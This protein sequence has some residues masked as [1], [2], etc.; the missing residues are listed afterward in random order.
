MGGART[1]P[2][3]ERLGE[4]YSTLRRAVPSFPFDASGLSSR[5]KSKIIATM[6]KLIQGIVEYRRRIRPAYREKFARLAL[7]QKPDALLIACSDS[8]VVPNLFASTEPGDLFVIRNVGN[9][10]PPFRDRN[11]RGLS[12]GAALEF[13]ALILGVKDVIVCGHS[14]CGAMEA[15]LA[16]RRRRR[17]ACLNGWL[18]SALPALERLDAGAR[19]KAGLSRSNQLS[20][21]NVLQQLE[22]IRSYPAI[23]KLVSTGTLRL[24]AWWFDIAAA[25]VLHFRPD[26]KGFVAIDE[27]EAARLL[28]EPGP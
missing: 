3:L 24:H 7:G 14:S 22:H 8:R 25:E 4:P 9:L 19:I 16:G 27:T 23:G 13:A 17:S 28:E 5:G 18:A 12:E 20:Q 10:I 11:E 21:L 26:G 6:R 15:L 1:M 2:T